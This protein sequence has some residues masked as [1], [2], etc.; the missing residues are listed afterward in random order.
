MQNV[1]EYLK[2]KVKKF[3]P[4]VE[5]SLGLKYQPK[6]DFTLELK[7]EDAAYYQSLFCV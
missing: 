6:I 5:M 4:R 3:P 7:V 1:E 2:E